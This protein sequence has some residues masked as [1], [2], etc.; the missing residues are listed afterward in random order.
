[1]LVSFVCLVFADLAHF[2]GVPGGDSTV[3]LMRIISL[4]FGVNF[5]ENGQ[6]LLGI[7]KHISGRVCSNVSSLKLRIIQASIQTQV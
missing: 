7:F 3:H 6:T 2:A 5:W 1:M 4:I